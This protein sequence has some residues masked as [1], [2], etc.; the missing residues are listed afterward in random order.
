MVLRHALLIFLVVCF[1]IT[2][3][4]PARADDDSLPSIKQALL[5][6]LNYGICWGG[7]GPGM[8][9]PYRLGQ[10]A[11]FLLARGDDKG[12]F[13]LWSDSV[14]APVGPRRDRFAFIYI[15]VL[16]GS[17]AGISDTES[18]NESFAG[19]M[20]WVQ[21]ET[22]RFSSKQVEKITIDIPRD[23]VMSFPPS[24]EKT[25][26]LN[27][28]VST[29]NHLV[30]EANHSGHSAY[31]VPL[32]AIVADFDTYYPSTFVYIEETGEVYSV[33]LHN[34]DDYFDD[35]DLQ[36]DLVPNN[37]GR[38]PSD[39]SLVKKIKKYGITVQVTGK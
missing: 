31:I 5:N 35:S 4:T 25:L 19:N 13:Y 22:A 20:S 12:K 39:D 10:T 17:D 1:G 33:G 30:S 34:S 15:G 29:L 27:A 37:L 2:H 11:T 32:T 23:C 36:G 18:Y 26:K 6:Y 14:A 9:S 16:S 21:Q 7:G 24:S 28:V 38:F 8:G 3:P